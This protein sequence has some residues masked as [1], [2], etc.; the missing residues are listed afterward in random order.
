M[1]LK[2]KEEA[3]IDMHLENEY[4]RINKALDCDLIKMR[5]KKERVKGISKSKN[6]SSFL[7]DDEIE[8]TSQEN[9]VSDSSHSISHKTNKSQ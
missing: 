8:E 9:S 5:K 4:V 7:T 2:S 3:I 1:N 6:D